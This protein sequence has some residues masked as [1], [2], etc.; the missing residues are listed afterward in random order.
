ML[1]DIGL[2]PAFDNVSLSY[3]EAGGHV[4][5]ALTAGAGWPSERRKRALDVIVRHNW[6]TVDPDLDEEGYLLEAATALDV[7]GARAE[8]IPVVC[9]EAVLA[10]H[11][12]GTLGEEFGTCVSQQAERKPDSAARRIV[13]AGLTGRLAHHPHAERG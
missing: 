1:H 2:V 5:V 3:E 11:P 7:L 9:V 10:E 12:R 13:D 8:V 4:A 6:A